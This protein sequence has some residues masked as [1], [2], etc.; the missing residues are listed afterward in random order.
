M[1]KIDMVEVLT[2]NRDF[3][4]VYE[5]F[6]MTLKEWEQLVR[7]VISEKDYPMNIINK[8]PDDKVTVV[9]LFSDSYSEAISLLLLKVGRRYP[10]PKEIAEAYIA[11]FVKRRELSEFR[12]LFD[13][14]EKYL[15]EKIREEIEG[16]MVGYG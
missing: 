6:G 13:K 1:K 8:Y 4:Y 5:A 9:A 7:E 15:I 16:V 10:T 12:K 2:S 14:A 11:I 3:K